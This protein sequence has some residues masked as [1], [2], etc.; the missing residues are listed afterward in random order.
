MRG[1][2]P[3]LGLLIG[4]GGVGL[5][6][7]QAAFVYNFNSAYTIQSGQSGSI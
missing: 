7:K 4:K 2:W 6:S 3:N 1:L 5:A